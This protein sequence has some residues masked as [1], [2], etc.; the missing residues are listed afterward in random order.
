M[1]EQLNIQLVDSFFLMDPGETS[2]GSFKIQI[3]NDSEQ[4]IPCKLI[5]VKI[6]YG[7]GSE[8]KHLTNSNQVEDNLPNGWDKYPVEDDDNYVY[9][10]VVN[11]NDGFSSGQEELLHFYNITF[12]PNPDGISE[13]EVSIEVECYDSEELDNRL[14]S[15][16]L[17]FTLKNQSEEDIRK[18]PFVNYFAF[19]SLEDKNR[20][21]TITW[22]IAHG[23]EMMIYPRFLTD[24]DQKAA[25]AVQ[26]KTITTLSDQDPQPIL[27][28]SETPIKL[29]KYGDDLELEL[30]NSMYFTLTPDN[31]N[32]DQ[33]WSQLVVYLKELTVIDFRVRDY[34]GKEPYPYLQPLHLDWTISYENKVAAENRA[35]L[36][37]TEYDNNNNNLPQDQNSPSPL[38]R[39][40]A[41]RV[42][43]LNPRNNQGTYT[44]FP[45]RKTTFTLY[46]S[47]NNGN[48]STN[49][50]VNTNSKTQ[51]LTIMTTSASNPIGSIIML[52]SGTIPVGWRLCGRYAKITRAEI[53]DTFDELARV[54]GQTNNSGT[55]N[56]PNMSNYFPV[57]AGTHRRLGDHGSPDPLPSHQHNVDPPNKRF[58]TNSTGNHN[59]FVGISWHLQHADNDDN[60]GVFPAVKDLKAY[61]TGTSGNH[62]HYVDVNIPNTR[63]SSPVSTASSRNRPYHY[64]VNFIIRVS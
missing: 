50:D 26:E 52:P 7:E 37:I 28:N 31:K 8:E 17:P 12:L 32:A 25:S 5:R 30:I 9:I 49:I 51:S 55:I 42:V 38:G 33:K 18:I 64:A 39:L 43:E 13:R 57:G 47:E 62:R 58:Y 46:I 14:Q 29:T 45:V 34:G 60:D 36:V 48:N 23:K 22:D 63:S 59:H 20:K 16:S 61:K 1:E 35:Q 44:Y 19:K 15:K 56:L 4:D 27:I 3:Q 41:T 21:V 6:P 54:L 2:Q 53:P 24:Q 10:D 40:L 11:P